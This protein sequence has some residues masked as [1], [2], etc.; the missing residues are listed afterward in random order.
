MKNQFWALVWAGLWNKR[1]WADYEQLL[2]PVF[3]SFY[4]QKI[5]L[6]FFKVYCRVCTEKLHRIKVNKS[7][8]ILGS[9]FYGGKMQRL[10]SFFCG[11][12]ESVDPALLKWRRLWMFQSGVELTYL[13]STQGCLLLFWKEQKIPVFQNVSRNSII[14]WMRK[15]IFIYTFLNTANIGFRINIRNKNGTIGHEN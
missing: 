11:V 15:L 3:L 6:N 4:G 1:V 2:R 13:S 7:W 10:L 5:N 8:K 14:Q 12:S 9:I